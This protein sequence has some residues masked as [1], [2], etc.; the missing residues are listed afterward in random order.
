MARFILVVVRNGDLEAS[1]TQYSILNQQT[2]PLTLTL[3]H[4]LRSHVTRLCFSTFEP[5]DSTTD[6][7][8]PLCSCVGVEGSSPRE[9]GDEHR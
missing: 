4:S 8:L 7:E 6:F 9:W 2:L 3:F 5:A 1:H